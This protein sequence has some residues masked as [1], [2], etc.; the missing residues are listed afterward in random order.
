MLKHTATQRKVRGREE[1]RDVL[2]KEGGVRRG[3]VMGLRRS[4][5]APPRLC[6]FGHTVD[7]RVLLQKQSSPGTIRYR[8]ISLVQGPDVQHYPCPMSLNDTLHVR[9]ATAE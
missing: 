8:S 5:G 2:G 4:R 6:D 9:E 1:A 7:T 3:K